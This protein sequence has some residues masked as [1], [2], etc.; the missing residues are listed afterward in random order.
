MS[1]GLSGFASERIRMP[2]AAPD[3]RVPFKMRSA[4]VVSTVV[5]CA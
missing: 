1:T 5:V 3:I 4:R 2:V